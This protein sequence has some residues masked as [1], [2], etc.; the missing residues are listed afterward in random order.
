MNNKPFDLQ[1]ALAGEPVVTRNGDQ[2]IRVV[3]LPE[4]KDAAY[5]VV[6]VIA[7]RS[8]PTIYFEDGKIKRDA[9]GLDLFMAPVKKTVWVNMWKDPATALIRCSNP[10]LQTEQAAKE[11]WTAT[12]HG[13]IGTYPIE[14]EL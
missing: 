2:V 5:K 11:H 6:A 3:H 9:D 7:G 4:V 14:I 10:A 13:F 1:K 8:V 12:M